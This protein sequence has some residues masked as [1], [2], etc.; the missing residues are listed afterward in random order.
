MKYCTNDRALRQ[1]TSHGNV[2]EVVVVV[3][4]NAM[5]SKMQKKKTNNYDKVV[6]KKGT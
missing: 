1:D 5:D 2:E 3:V 4:G 6:Q